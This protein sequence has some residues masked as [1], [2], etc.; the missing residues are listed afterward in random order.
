MIGIIVTGHG[1]FGSGI[2]SA[3][4][5]L[6]GYSKDFVAVD[7][8]TETDTLETFEKKIRDARVSLG[9]CEDIIVLCDIL[10]GTPFKTAVTAFFNDHHVKVLYGTNVGMALKLCM[11]CMMLSDGYDIDAICDSLC[12]EAKMHV[13][14]YQFVAVSQ[15]DDMEDG[16]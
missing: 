16:I 9:H 7:Y 6:S 5:T 4:T 3:A 10:G 11:E 12:D 1:G 15:E 13:G 2:Y 14:K 8:L